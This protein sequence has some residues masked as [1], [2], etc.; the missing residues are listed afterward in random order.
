MDTLPG[1]EVRTGP[2]IRAGLYLRVS[3]DRGRMGLAVRRQGEDCRQVAERLGWS[4]ACVYIDNGLSASQFATK[5]RD[6]YK[7]LLDDIKAGRLD[8][9]V[10]WMEDRSHRQVLELAEFV[11]TC[12]TAGLSRYASVG[13]EYDLSDPDQVTMLFSMAR[14]SEIEVGR[15]SIRVK[16]SLE[17]LAKAGQYHGG[18]KAYGYEGPI[19][20]E[21]GF[22]ANQARIGKAV[23]DDE[24]MIIR[25]A[26]RRI[27]N[28]ES[29]RSVVLGFNQ[30]GIPAPRG[31]LWTRRTLKVILTHPRVAGLRQHQGSV[32]GRAHWPAILDHDTWE[33]V[34]LVLLSPDRGGARTTRRMYLLTGFIYCGK[35][36]KRLAGMPYPNGTRAYGCS[37]GTTYR[38]CGGVR[39]KAEPVE[40]LI[41]EAILSHF[42]DS[43]ELLRMLEDAD[44]EGTHELQA[45]YG[46][47]TDDTSALD[48]LADDYYV[49]RAI[50]KRQFLRSCQALE[51]R[52]EV[53]KYT[54]TELESGHSR[55]TVLR[56]LAAA[57]SVRQ[58]WEDASHDRRRELIDALIEQVVVLPQA[59]STFNPGSIRVAW[60]VDEHGLTNPA[61]GSRL[62]GRLLV[63]REGLID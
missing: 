52:I 6:D 36:G 21:N 1:E 32:V 47:L 54:L 53:T 43:P 27:L 22:V 18:P 9:V 26:A 11:K 51:D 25:E 40:Y 62:T 39:R 8:A 58:A 20:D 33:R 44:D 23:I 37:V 7:R 42:D 57:E 30:R 38:G 49:K 60:R 34:R 41:R 59:T 24:A 45:L 2:Q 13:T 56:T 16:R 15:I 28:G 17:E 3:R 29:L 63:G 12:R 5:P 19:K 31:T 48:E 35:C 61:R 14:M 10:V 55:T 50:A 46:Q 4:V